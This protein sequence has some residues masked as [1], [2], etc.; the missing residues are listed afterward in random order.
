MNIDNPIGQLRQE[1]ARLDCLDPQHAL[2]IGKLAVTRGENPQR[3]AA[4][5]MRH[6]PGLF[7]AR[8]D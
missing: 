5:I 4:S 8:Q 7:V 1:L 3:I 6:W 2:Q